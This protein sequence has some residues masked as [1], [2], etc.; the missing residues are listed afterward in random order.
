MK[1]SVALPPHFKGFFEI[2]SGCFEDYEQFYSPE[3]KMAHDRSCRAHNR[4][5]H[6]RERASR[7]AART[8]DVTMFESRGLIGILIKQCIAVL[9]KKLD[10]DRNPRNNLTAQMEDYLNQEE[11]EGIEAPIKLIAGYTENKETGEMAG[12]YIIRPSG[13]GHNRWELQLTS[14]ETAPMATELFEEDDEIQEA[15]VTKRREP[16]IVIPFKVD[17]G[18]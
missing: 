8:P 5:A 2:I 17:D 9:F 13:I 12:A 16:A 14:E 6:M 11:I 1:L 10:D 7:Y 3:A 15:D 18:K 4:N